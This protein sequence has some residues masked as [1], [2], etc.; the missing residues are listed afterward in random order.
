MR[1]AAGVNVTQGSLSP[2]DTARFSAVIALD[3]G[4]GGA[5]PAGITERVCQTVNHECWYIDFLQ[6]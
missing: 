2:I 3:G 4:R 6:P 5:T 1:V